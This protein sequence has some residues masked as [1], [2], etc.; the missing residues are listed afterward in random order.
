M[1]RKSKLAMTVALCAVAWRPAGAQAPSAV[2][3]DVEVQNAVT[4]INDLADL[5][6]AATSSSPVIPNLAS[7][8]FYSTAVTIGDIVSVNGTPAKG[9]VV[10]RGQ[11]LILGPNPLP[12][13]AIADISG[14]FIGDVQFEI[15]QPDGTPI[16]LLRADIL[17]GSAPPLTGG[18]G[19]F[20]GARGMLTFAP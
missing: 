18:T 10:I 6:K 1:N 14:P 16:G 13:Q 17:G 5:S 3:L 8:K 9:T 12:G 4:Y 15:L 19:A 11:L 20:L 7:V 2:A